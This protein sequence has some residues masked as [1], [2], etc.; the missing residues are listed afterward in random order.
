MN[1]HEGRTGKINAC[2]IGA[3][4]D[5][6]HARHCPW[7]SCIVSRIVLI[8]PYRMGCVE[9]PCDCLHWEAWW[10]K[11]WRMESLGRTAFVAPTALVMAGN[12]ASRL[13]AWAQA[14]KTVLAASTTCHPHLR[15]CQCGTE[16][17]QSG[18]TRNCLQI[19][20]C[21]PWTLQAGSALA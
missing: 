20:W 15:A 17:S 7:Q 5:D 19:G 16:A 9:A 3:C 2:I 10:M 21:K 14:A 13:R 18:M 1:W 6:Q 11:K 8:Q 12:R 4:S